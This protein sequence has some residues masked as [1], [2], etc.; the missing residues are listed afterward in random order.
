MTEPTGL[1]QLSYATPHS[2]IEQAGRP[3]RTDGARCELRDQRPGP[4]PP[5]HAAAC[6]EVADWQ[7]PAPPGRIDR[8]DSPVVEAAPSGCAA[9][10][11][12]A[13]RRHTPLGP[14]QPDGG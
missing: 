11:A 5:P 3:G 12:P 4:N 2:S 14:G 10:P 9:V 6:R 1:E 13:L 8:P 7:Q